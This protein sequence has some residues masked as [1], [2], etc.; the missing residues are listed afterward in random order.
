MDLHV[1]YQ[2]VLR[3][4]H[5][6]YLPVMSTEVAIHVFSRFIKDVDGAPTRTMTLWI[7]TAGIRA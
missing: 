3:S 4:T 7:R 1:L 6:W 5:W 2:S